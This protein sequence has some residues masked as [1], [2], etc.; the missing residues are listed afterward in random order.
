MVWASSSLG[1]QTSLTKHQSGNLA[2]HFPPNDL[3]FGRTAAG[4]TI[5]MSADG[6]RLAANSSANPLARIARL[7]RRIRIEVRL[8]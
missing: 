8:C 3:P 6:A 5:P 4:A 7:C 2:V 1:P